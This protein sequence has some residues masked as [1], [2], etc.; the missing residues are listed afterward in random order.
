M[1][2]AAFGFCSK[3]RDPYESDIFLYWRR[4]QASHRSCNG[5][6]PKAL[7]VVL[8][9]ASKIELTHP[10]ERPLGGG[11]FHLLRPNRWLETVLLFHFFALFRWHG[12]T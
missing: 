6:R 12:S 3:P 8:L 4:Q 5:L 10:H 2:S 11:G 7:H 9:S 1:P